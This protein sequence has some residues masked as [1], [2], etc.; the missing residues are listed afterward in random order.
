MSGT[1]DRREWLPRTRTPVG[2]RR[3]WAGASGLK[4][5]PQELVEVFRNEL[6]AHR[7]SKRGHQLEQLR[8]VEGLVR[9]QL[10]HLLLHRFQRM[11]H[12][13]QL[14]GLQAGGSDSLHHLVCQSPL[15]RELLHLQLAQALELF[16]SVDDRL[17]V[18]FVCFVHGIQ[19]SLILR[20]TIETGI[21]MLGMARGMRSRRRSCC[22]TSGGTRRASW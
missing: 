3:S 2:N 5:L 14:G 6:P 9:V 8:A 13:A 15:Q 21:R 11:E 19:S 16:D 22:T 1:C 4:H 20:L 18:G 10:L 7:V 12:L 17:N